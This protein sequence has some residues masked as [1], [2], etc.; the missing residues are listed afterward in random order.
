MRQ[1]EIGDWP[2]MAGEGRGWH[3]MRRV[4]VQRTSSPSHHP[5]PIPGA[6]WHLC[7]NGDTHRNA[8]TA[9]PSTVSSCLLSPVFFRIS[10]LS[11]GGGCWGGICASNLPAGIVSSSVRVSFVARWWLSLG[12]KMN[13]M[14]LK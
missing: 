2:R 9:T 7:P 11:R 6:K 5:P 10:S 14:L 8:T 3:V 1:K 13:Y 12:N 4:P